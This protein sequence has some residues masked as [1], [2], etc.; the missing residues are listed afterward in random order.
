MLSKRIEYVEN[1]AKP[2]GPDK[3]NHRLARWRN[4]PD[5]S[6]FYQATLK[7]AKVIKSTFLS[8]DTAT[9]Y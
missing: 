8:A 1:L 3:K 6:E 5:W 2:K 7:Y 4:Q 9:I